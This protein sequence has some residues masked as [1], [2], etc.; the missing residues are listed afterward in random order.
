MPKTKKSKKQPTDEEL[1]IMIRT[2][3][4]KVNLQNTGVKAFIALLQTECGDISLK[5]RQAFIKKSLEEAINELDDDDDDSEEEEEEDEEEE[6]APAKGKRQT[7]LSVQKEI[8][9]ELAKFLGH[10]SGHKMARTEIVKQLWAYI[11]DRQL[12]NPDNKREIFLDT[13][14]K[15]VFKVDMVTMFTLNKYISAH[16]HP[17]KPVDLTTKNKSPTTKKKR[18]ASS[19]SKESKASAKKKRKPKQPGL[20]PP[21]RLSAELADV[22]GADVLPRPQ[23]VSAVWVYIKSNNLQVRRRT[24]F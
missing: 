23:V 22:V 7:G 24:V 4:P 17:Y 9:P 2:L 14:L 1:K 16:V 12:Q 3:I 11:R 6:E 20:Q 21:Y 13:K 10:T 5:S 18:K 15:K 19:S 8:S